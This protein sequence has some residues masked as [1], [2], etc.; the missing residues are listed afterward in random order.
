MPSI[1][2][3]LSSLKVIVNG[4]ELRGITDLTI[5]RSSEHQMPE[6]STSVQLNGLTS[7]GKMWS[8]DISGCEVYVGED[9]LQVKVG[10]DA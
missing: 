2:F 6:T 5:Q 3:S 8:L 10:I 1:P 7:S 9:T 4:A